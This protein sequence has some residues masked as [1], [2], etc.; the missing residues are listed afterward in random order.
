MTPRKEL[1]LADEQTTQRRYSREL[2]AKA[3]QLIQVQGPRNNFWTGTGM[4]A[5]GTMPTGQL[6]GR[7][8]LANPDPDLNDGSDFY[9]GEARADVDGVRVFS[10]AAT[11]GLSP[12]FRNG[13]LAG[14]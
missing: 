8:A 10:W 13:L 14:Q 4:P 9:I 7:I 2:A 3:L 11:V 1:D 6:I 12:A 5:R